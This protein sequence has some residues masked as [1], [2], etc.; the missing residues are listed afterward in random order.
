[1]ARV[2]PPSVLFAYSDDECN[3]GVCSELASSLIYEFGNR[4]VQCRCVPL[5]SLLDCETCNDADSKHLETEADIF[6]ELIKLCH[7]ESVRKGQPSLFTLVLIVDC[8]R[9][10]ADIDAFAATV[11][12][13]VSDFR[14][15]KTLLFGLNFAIVACIDDIGGTVTA[16]DRNA[17]ADVSSLLLTVEESLNGL[18]ANHLL[19]KSLCFGRGDIGQIVTFT[20]LVYEAWDSII[21]LGLRY[22][23]NKRRHKS[24]KKLTDRVTPPKSEAVKR[25]SPLNAATDTGSRDNANENDA[26]NEVSVTPAKCCTASGRHSTKDNASCVCAENCE[27]DAISDNEEIGGMCSP[28]DDI[29]NIGS[30]ADRM[31]SDVQRQSLMKQGYKLIGDHSAIKLCRWTKARVRGHGGC[32]KHTFY[33]IKSNQC[34]EMTPSLACANKCV[35]CWRHHTN[36]VSTRWKWPADDPDFLA[37]ESVKAHLKLIKEL[38]GIFDTKSERLSEAMNV[39]HCA[40]SL[41]GEPIMYPQINELLFELH[42]RH[43]STFLVTNAQFPKEMEHLRQVTQLYLSIDGADETTLKNTD[44]PLFRDFWARFQRCIQLLRTRKERTVFRLTLVKNFNISEQQDEISD[45][46]RLIELGEPDF[47]E[48]KAVTFCGTVHDNAITMKNVPWHDEVIRYAE[49]LV[50]ATAFT[51]ENY[52]IACEHRHSCCVLIAK[53]CFRIEGRWHTWIDYDKFHELAMSGRDFHGLEYSVA[54]PE[55]ALFGSKEEGFDPVDTRVYTK[56]RRKLPGPP[57]TTS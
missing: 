51:R 40:L 21:S 2:P 19:D 11:H 26:V 43:I 18:G 5:R 13:W 3:S 35:F 23:R 28:E 15:S 54:T 36:P 24:D 42:Q 38:R 20:N 45:Y 30:G 48:I 6:C 10:S 16:R 4:D 1:M 44:R 47:I 39:R 7:S 33:G 22:K 32:Y 29:E 12:D 27:S 17:R 14:I 46:G 57:G 9:S 34:M 37:E 41:V 53:Q 55:W 25:E 56:G 31:V 52:A 8:Q 50:D 49:A